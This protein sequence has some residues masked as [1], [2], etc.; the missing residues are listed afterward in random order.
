MT[1]FDHCHQARRR[2]SPYI[3]G[4][5]YLRLRTTAATI[6]NSFSALTRP[7][8][9]VLKCRVDILDETEKSFKWLEKLQEIRGKAMVRK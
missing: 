6:N 7:G 8:N 5:N 9:V 3:A 1:I 4:R 2:R